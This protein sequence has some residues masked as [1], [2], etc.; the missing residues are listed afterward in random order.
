MMST[1]LLI[2]GATLQ[3]QL[4]ANPRVSVIPSARISA[5]M[6][7]TEAAALTDATDWNALA[8][9]L[10]DVGRHREA[11]AAYER[12]MQLG[13]ADPAR[14]AFNVARAYAHLENRRQA[15]RW[16]EHAVM[17]G[18]ADHELVR[19]E[20]E[21]DRYRGDERFQEIVDRVGLAPGGRVV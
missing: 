13:T 7:L 1:A 20:R 14:A 18:L 2:I 15:L 8:D 5:A 10:H 12:A 4:P 17:L 16:L 9:S 19:A 6:Q 3:S 21:F 11:I